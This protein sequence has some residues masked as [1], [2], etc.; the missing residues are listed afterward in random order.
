MYFACDVFD[1]VR[2][3]VST[4]INWFSLT[5][6]GASV[7]GNLA[8]DFLTAVYDD[9]VNVSMQRFGGTEVIK[10]TY[11]WKQTATYKPSVSK[12]DLNDERN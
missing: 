8:C 7:V 1:V 12:W 9:P 11:G 3:R 6:G 2:R 5:L 10:H 4:K